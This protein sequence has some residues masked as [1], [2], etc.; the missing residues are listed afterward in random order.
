MAE[1]ATNL[2]VGLH[3]QADFVLVALGDDG[4]VL[5]GSAAGEDDL[6]AG[7]RQNRGTIRH[8]EVAVT[9][10]DS[11]LQ[12]VSSV[13][14]PL[15][16]EL[17]GTDT[18][19]LSDAVPQQLAISRER[20]GV[21]V[22]GAADCPREHE[23][24]H[25]RII[26]RV[27]VD[28]RLMDIEHERVVRLQQE[29]A[30]HL[31]EPASQVE[32]VDTDLGESR[33]RH[34][35]A[36]V[37]VAP[38]HFRC[39]GVERRREHAIEH[40]SRITGFQAL[41]FLGDLPCD[42][43]VGHDDP[44]EDCPLVAGDHPTYDVDGIAPDR[45]TTGVAMLD[46]DR[47][48]RLL[49]EVE[50]EPSCDVRH[51]LQ[52][53]VHVGQT[54]EAPL[55]AL[56]ELEL[57]NGE[58]IGVARRIECGRSHVRVLAVLEVFDLFAEETDVLSVAHPLHDREIVTSD[59]SEG[60]DCKA[61]SGGGRQSDV[62][63]QLDEDGLILIGTGYDPDV[64]VV[65]GCCPHHSRTADVDLLDR[66]LGLERIQVG[67]D[68]VERLDAVLLHVRLVFGIGRNRQD[69]TVDVWVQGDNT[70][71]QDRREAREFGDVGRGQACVGD[72]LRGTTR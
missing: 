61:L 36:L 71:S 65:L 30:P 6:D 13:R 43:E 63:A 17:G 20:D 23:V 22:A 8:G 40:A 12:V 54:D 51:D 44:A 7:L 56:H 21:A 29:P 53:A 45:R 59:V 25:L 33:V 38:Q 68:E 62:I 58:R 32:R 14:C 2:S 9:P 39:V 15:D 11:T 70:V 72:C 16:G 31:L 47:D 4:V 34:H 1:E 37:L 19:L 3:Q 57:V 27:A 5:L 35:A 52:Q 41:Q 28:R 66:R 55:V 26:R 49:S 67:D 18:V 10:R 50:R 69:A 46:T 48:E 24:F 42:R 64:G 60:L